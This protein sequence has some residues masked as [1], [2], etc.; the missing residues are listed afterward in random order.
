M[1]IE[2][3]GLIGCGLM[4]SGI[5]LSLLRRRYKVYVLQHLGNKNV[6]LLIKKGAKFVDEPK[7]ISKICKVIILCLPNANTVKDVICGQ[8]GVIKYLLKSSIIIDTTT[9]NPKVTENMYNL[10]LTKEI[11]YVDA[12]LTRSP[13]EAKSGKL[14]VIVGANRKIYDTIYPILTSFSENIFYAGDVGNAHKLKLLNNFICMSFIAIVEYGVFCGKK[15]NLDLDLLNSI[16]SVG[17]N[18][19]QALP[20]M[21]NWVKNK[22][23]PIL[24]FSLKNATKDMKYFF[25]LIEFSKNK[26]YFS[27]LLSIYE[28]AIKNENIKEKALPYLYEFFETFEKNDYNTIGRRFK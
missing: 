20:L 10:L 23:Q 18:Y 8:S 22:N 19:V 27:N 28:H 26:R 21:I 17:S 7:E 9:S 11:N 13:N 4:G 24:N 14:N 15:L 3:V 12:P 6:D 2:N 16:M 25:E 5:C 1:K